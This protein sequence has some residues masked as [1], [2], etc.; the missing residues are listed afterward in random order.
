MNA[1]VKLIGLV[2]TL[3]AITG[4]PLFGLASVIGIT[5]VVAMLARVR[6]SSLLGR[7]AAIGLVVVPMVL[8]ATWSSAEGGR[9]DTIARTPLR[10]FASGMV[11]VLFALT[12]TVGQWTAVLRT[13]R[14]PPGLIRTVELVYRYLA[15]LGE[16]A[17]T[18][19]TAARNR[20]G[21]RFSAATGILTALFARSWQRA[22][23]VERAM[24][25]RGQ[26][27]DG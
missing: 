26:R 12:T 13:W 25:A 4:L 16:E 23:A 14:V 6:L 1:Q 24:L 21:L 10:A 27:E 20:G 9:W 18:M 3:I 11:A 15:L 17:R 8:L 7:T 2:A 19:Q 22:E 5:I